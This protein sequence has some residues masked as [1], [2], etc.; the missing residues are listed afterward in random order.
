MDDKKKMQDQD[1]DMFEELNDEE[2]LWEEEEWDI[3]TVTTD[4][5]VEHECTV[6]DIFTIE[7]SDQEYV[8]LIGLDD[9][10]EEE[11]QIYL[12]RYSDSE[13]DPDALE[14]TMIEDEEEFEKVREEFERRIDELEDEE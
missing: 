9:A 6:L 7:G 10:P 13:E 14:I 3:I 12:Y 4:D 2:D 1:L 11:A 5:D 8:A